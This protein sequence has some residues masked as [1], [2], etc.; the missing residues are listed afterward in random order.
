MRVSFKQPIIESAS[1]STPSSHD[2]MFQLTTS[3]KSELVANCDHLSGLKF[4]R[5][6]PHAFTARGDHRRESSMP[7]P[8]PRGQRRL[9]SRHTEM[10]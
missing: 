2:L 4:A 7:L 5:A 1:A 3:E 6:L 8:P 10:R 9:G